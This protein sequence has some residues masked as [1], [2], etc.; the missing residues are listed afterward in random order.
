MSTSQKLL[1]ELRGLAAGTEELIEEVAD[2]SGNRIAAARDRARSAVSRARSELAD[3][4][5][6]SSARA[7]AAGIAA[8]D[9]VHVNPWP[10][11]AGVAVVALI[12]GALLA[13]R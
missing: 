10:T 6:A 13:R 12:A 2:Q 11:I 9:Y 5:H 1:S 3:L 7:R 8:D 4:A